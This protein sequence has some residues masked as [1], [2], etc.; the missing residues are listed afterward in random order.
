MKK[1][2]QLLALCALVILVLTVFACENP[3]IP[4]KY[5]EPPPPQAPVVNVEAAPISPYVK[6][7]R[8]TIEAKASVGDGGELSYQWYSNTK[9][10][11]SGGNKISYATGASY[12]P[13]TDIESALDTKYYYVEVTNTIYGRTTTAASRAVDIT[14]YDVGNDT[15]IREINVVVVAPVKGAEP[16]EV[17][18]TE[19]GYN[20]VEM[21]WD[22][23]PKVFQER[24]Q[25]TVTVKLQAEPNHTLIALRAAT[26]N[27]HAASIKRIDG[28][29]VELSYQFAEMK[30]VDA[31]EVKSEPSW[32]YTHGDMLNLNGLVLTLTFND[33]TTEDVAAVNFEERD[34][35]TVPAHDSPLSHTNHNGNPIVVSCAGVTVNT[36]NL[37]V[38]KAQ[39]TTA[40]VTITSPAKNIAPVTSATVDSSAAYAPGTVSWSVGN[41]PF[42]GGTFLGSTSYTA[43]V[44]L[45][46]D[47]DHVFANVLTGHINNSVAVISNKTD[48]SV[49]LSLKFD[50][51]FAGELSSI[52]VKTQPTKLSYTHGDLLDLAGLVVTLNFS[53]ANPIDE[54]FGVSNILLMQPAQDD[55]LRYDTHNG[56]PVTVNY[57]GQSAVTNNLTVNKKALTLNT[58][59][60][61][62]TKVYD[63]NTTAN[64]ITGLTLN[65]IVGSDNVYVSA[66]N[67]VYTNKDVET[68]KYV[69]ITSA[70]LAGVH[71][72]NYTVTLSVDNVPVTGGITK[73][74]TSINTSP[75]PTIINY[76]QPLS[77]STLS[78]GS[79][80]VPGTFAWTNPATVPSAGFSYSVSITFIPDDSVNY[81]SRIGTANTLTVKP[82]ITF[83]LNGGSLNGSTNDYIIYVSPYTTVSVPENPTLT[84]YFFDGWYTDAALTTL[85][86]FST[87]VTNNN[88]TLYAG[89]F[90]ETDP[91]IEEITS[92]PY[93]STTMAMAYVNG[94][95]FLRGQDG[96]NSTGVPII[97]LSSFFI[98]KYE[99]TQEQFQAVMGK[100]PS[101]FQGASYPPDAGEVQ[102]K[103]PV[104]QV[105]WFDA[106]EFCN[107][108]SDLE[109]LQRVYTFNGT[110]TR[111]N[112][113]RDGPIGMITAVSGGVT[114][115][116]TKNGYRLPTNAEWEYA[117]KGGHQMSNPPYI[118]SGSDT[119]D[120]V[121]WYSGNS[122]SST[123]EVGKK[124]PNE[125]DIYDMTGNVTEWCWDWIGS[126]TDNGPNPTGNTVGTQRAYRGGGYSH[127]VTY[128]RLV[129]ITGFEP[130]YCINSGGFRVARI[131]GE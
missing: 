31:M 8:V 125:L 105:S 13:S 11:N 81:N 37:T 121:A 26:I 109:G 131:L 59:N 94:G 124:L 34:I 76:G 32:T 54:V 15:P 72:D 86:A 82:R 129:Y 91:R 3:F 98:S 88:I 64:G 84:G 19:P 30:S 48:T 55:V 96:D 130:R 61:A 118:Y 79:A 113:S 56:Q 41:A 35:R 92:V 83:V 36:N 18:N 47:G 69:N 17:V 57:S 78:G 51:T 77:A 27:G 52:T 43:A 62:H 46:A 5:K 114:A 21:E 93:S 115:N 122:S 67:G 28:N 106:L 50:D 74:N 7:D 14:V 75:T 110:I 104:E 20:C 120:D 111:N 102:A 90:E 53:D 39:I 108:L 6:G 25:Y 112:D 66:A 80:S 40:H 95:T 87:Q 42:T 60:A 116:W 2:N 33:G 85:Y 38:N 68:Q 99:V 24:Y 49:T 29:A 71:A 119:A 126:G 16:S 103:R 63:T 65:G 123:H 44:T 107:K 89:W 100:N 23:W 101:R 127:S 12:R 4:G 10:S 97:S 22:P 1:R 117:A 70:T 58:A 73:A 9:N 128:L 45:T